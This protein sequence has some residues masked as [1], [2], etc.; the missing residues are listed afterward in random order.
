MVGE[1]ALPDPDTG[2]PEDTGR[3]TDEV[4]RNRSMA[5]E[6]VTLLI[7]IAFVIFFS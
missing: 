5:K 7:Q 3:N 1:A 4:I 2:A 6:T